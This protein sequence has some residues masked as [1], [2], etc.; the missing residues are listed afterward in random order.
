MPVKPTSTSRINENTF[1]IKGIAYE[2]STNLTTISNNLK[3]TKDVSF[4]ESLDIDKNLFVAG[5]TDL[6]GD[7]TLKALT[8]SGLATIQQ[9]KV[10]TTSEFV[11]EISGN[12]TLKVAGDVSLNSSVDVGSNLTIAGLTTSATL[13]T[14]D[15][16]TLDQLS[17]GTTSEFTGKVTAISDVSVN[18]GLDV[19]GDVSLNSSV[20]VGSNLTVIGL[21]TSA[22][23][24]TSDLA[25]L[26]QL[27]VGT[28]SEFTG[29]VTTLSDVSV[30]GGLYVAGD[31][32]LNSSVDVGSNLTVTGLTTTATLTTSDLATLDQLSVGTTSEFTG[33]VTAL[34]D[35]SVNGGL[36]VAG[37]VS[38]NS[39]VDVATNLS[40]GGTTNLTGSLTAASISGTT[41][42]SS[43][44]ATLN[45]LSVTNNASIGST[46]SVTNRLTALDDISINSNLLVGVDTTLGG[47]LDVVSD[48]SLNSALEVGGNLQVDGTSLL[49][50]DVTIEGSFNVLNSSFTYTKTTINSVNLDVSDNIL[51][52]NVKDVSMDQTTVLPAGIMVQDISTNKNLFF[53]YSGN[54]ESQAH[55]QQFVITRTNYDESSQDTSVLTYDKS[56]DVF[57]NG[58]LDVSGTLDVSGDVQIDGTLTAT[59]ITGLNFQV[60]GESADLSQGHFPF[61]YGAGGFDQDNS[62]GYPLMSNCNLISVGLMLADVSMASGDASVNYVT[63]DINGTEIS[64]NWLDDLSGFSTKTSASYPRKIIN[65]SFSEGDMVTIQCKELDL[66]SFP[67]RFDVHA[68]EKARIALKFKII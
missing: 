13:T 1:N 67:T 21:T 63:F 33:K 23:L 44:Q 46:L 43:S 12:S 22:T 3:V 15:L 64:F 41:I 5:T 48:V 20:D 50:G 17:V 68:V 60:V 52:I 19:A 45:S 49:K 58:S 40:V 36:E 34:S 14:S 27:S 2:N 32:S 38:L 55:S 66:N 28:T 18:G 11:Q 59:S 37:D 31:V 65:K 26:D 62:F 16:A 61:A 54:N 42:Q 39:S 9:L 25:T 24:T 35:V 30:N 6:S 7:L 51:R 4:N 53:G 10:T 47:R 56:V 57:L 8:T 29:K